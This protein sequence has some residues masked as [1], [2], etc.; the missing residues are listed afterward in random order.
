TFWTTWHDVQQPDGTVTWTSPSG[1]TYTTT[2]GGALFFPQLGAPT[3]EFDTV[4]RQRDSGES[5]T[6]M[7][8]TRRRSRAAERAA[9]ITWERGL[10]EARMDSSPPP[11]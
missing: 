3:E 10:N 11:F 6:E 2:P 5:R 9:R 4:V 8:P 7:M 1:R